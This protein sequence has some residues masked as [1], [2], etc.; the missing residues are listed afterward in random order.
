MAD[1]E[2]TRKPRIDCPVCGKNVAARK[3]GTVTNHYPLGGGERR[4]CPG[5]YR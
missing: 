2:R 5:G 4:W 3:D 1:E